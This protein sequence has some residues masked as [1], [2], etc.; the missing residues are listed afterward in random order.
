MRGRGIT[1]S[2]S[3]CRNV[4][5]WVQISRGENLKAIS[6]CVGYRGDRLSRATQTFISHVSSSRFVVSLFIEPLVFR[7][8]AVNFI[9]YR[10]IK[11]ENYPQISNLFFVSGCK[12]VYHNIR[13]Y[14]DRITAGA[15]SESQKNCK[16]WH[17]S[18]FKRHSTSWRSSLDGASRTA[19]PLL[20]PG[21]LSLNRNSKNEFKFIHFLYFTK[22]EASAVSLAKC[23][24]ALVSLYGSFRVS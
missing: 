14:G 2:C 4:E 8:A 20:H 1:G 15:S 22:F 3:S 9:H 23:A 24:A 5:K 17:P 18:H 19:F 13:V 10:V 11:Q 12:H 7:L 16:F 6:P 21:T